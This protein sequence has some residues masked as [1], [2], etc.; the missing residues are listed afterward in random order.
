MKQDEK[1]IKALNGIRNICTTRL[2]LE[3]EEVTEAKIFCNAPDG[4]DPDHA[5]T[6]DFPKGIKAT[7]PIFGNYLGMDAVD[8][9][10]FML[11]LEEEFN[12]EIDDTNFVPRNNI[13][14]RLLWRYRPVGD[15][16]DYC[17]ENM[18]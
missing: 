15:L 7:D 12:K 18:V 4:N 5:L 6:V 1:R 8:G 17:A 13:D 16:V 14:H 3:A 11:W 2:G 10:K 9:M